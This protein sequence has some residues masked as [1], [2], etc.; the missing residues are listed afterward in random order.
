MGDI[1]EREQ[2]AAP[3]D[4]IRV[5]GTYAGGGQPIATPDLVAWLL[6]HGRSIERIA[7]FVDEL[8]WRAVATG[9]P[10]WRVTLHT[11]TLHPQIQG[12][13][14]RWWRDRGVTE[15]FTIALG[16]ERE[17]GI[18]RQPDP[19]QRPGRRGR[20]LPPLRGARS[21][22]PAAGAAPGGGRDRLPGLAPVPASRPSPGHHL[23]DR[24]A[25][26]VHRRPRRAPLRPRRALG[27][28]DR[29]A[30]QATHRPRPAATP[31]SAAKPARGF[32]PAR[33]AVV[34]ASASGR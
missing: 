13:G 6:E 22:T 32:S 20:T 16:A 28:R 9:L 19:W 17:P 21:R 3:A 8:C 27:S 10:L 11:A 30:P 4:P 18:P 33:S 5:T 24:R 15:E 14:C 7:V 23:G 2:S 25:G 31:T 34:V 1:R 26:R 29:G 12:L